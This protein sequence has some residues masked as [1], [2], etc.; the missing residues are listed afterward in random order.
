MKN[1]ILIICFFLLVLFSGCENLK[2]GVGLKK[3]RP[4]EFLI[5]KRDPLVLP[6]DYQ[7]LPPD[8]KSTQKDIKEKSLKS[9]IDQSF[10]QVKNLSN[11]SNK[12]SSNLEQEVLKQIK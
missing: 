7:I 1:K 11:S 6:P 9:V 2:K 10:N 8:S 4:D 12:S 3:D 5:E